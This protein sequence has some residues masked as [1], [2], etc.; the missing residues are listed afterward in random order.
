MKILPRYIEDEGGKCTSSISLVDNLD[1]LSVEDAHAIANYM[2]SCTVIDEWLSNI[3]DPITKQFSIP[4]KTW[5]DGVYVWDSS[6][7]H[8]VKNY[9]V[10]L[11]GQFV[12]HVKYR[13]ALGFDFKTLMKDALRAE[14]ELILDKLLNGDESFYVTYDVKRFN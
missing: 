5:S 8:Y 1:V 3:R 7:I 11:P 13:V 6:H 14:F 2:E 9:R 4:S 12:D 10:R